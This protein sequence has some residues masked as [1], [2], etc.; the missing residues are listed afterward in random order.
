[1]FREETD[2]VRSCTFRVRKASEAVRQMRIDFEDLELSG[3]TDGDCVEERLVISGRNSGTVVPDI[4]GYN[5]GQHG[6]RFGVV[7]TRSSDRFCSLRRRV[8]PE[9]SSAADGVGERRREEEVQDSGVPTGRLLRGFFGLPPVPLRS[10]RRDLVVQLR[11]VRR[12]RPQ[13]PRILRKPPFPRR[14]PLKRSLPEQPQL[15][16]LHRE[17]AGLLLGD[18]HERP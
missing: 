4:C 5:T 14:P 10:S 12:E 7:G 11:P 1:M 9:R 17:T 15:R 2:D 8:R 3:P 16:R 18:L 13:R 6:E